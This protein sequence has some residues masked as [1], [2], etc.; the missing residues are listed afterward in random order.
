ML[1]NFGF[2]LRMH[3]PQVCLIELDQSQLVAPLER[4]EKDAA[5]ALLVEQVGTSPIL[6]VFVVG[7][8]SL[9]YL[10]TYMSASPPWR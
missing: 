7:L 4:E 2:L 8:L 6:H 10:F 9:S 3:L 1:L 5:E